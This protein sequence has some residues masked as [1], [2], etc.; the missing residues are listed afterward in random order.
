[1]VALGGSVRVDVSGWFDPEWSVDFKAP[2][3][4][5]LKVFVAED[6]TIRIKYDET[7][8][9]GFDLLAN[10]QWA[11]LYENLIPGLA[12]MIAYEVRDSIVSNVT[13][14]VGDIDELLFELPDETFDIGD[15]SV[16]VFPH[17]TDIRSYGIDGSYYLNFAGVMDTSVNTR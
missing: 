5:R 2:L 9:P 14:V 17:I 10:N 4:V 15:K 1:M 13:D 8:F 16:T 6:K 11:A 12:K 3:D 7:H